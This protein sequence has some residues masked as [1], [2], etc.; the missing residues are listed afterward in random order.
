MAPS[1]NHQKLQ[2]AHKATWPK[3]TQPETWTSY[4]L[5]LTCHEYEESQRQ[6]QEMIQQ[7]QSMPALSD[8]ETEVDPQEAEDEMNNLPSPLHTHSRFWTPEYQ[9]QREARKRLWSPPLTPP[10]S[11]MPKYSLQ[12]SQRPPPPRPR[13]RQLSPA[14]TPP[15]PTSPS[16]SPHIQLQLPPNSRFNRVRKYKPHSPPHRPTIRSMKTSEQ[17]S[18]HVPRG[19]VEVL[20]TAGQGRSTTFE[21]CLKDGIVWFVLP[22][23][24]HLNFVRLGVCG[25][26]EI[27]CRLIDNGRKYQLMLL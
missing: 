2:C 10:L 22:L 8:N 17:L 3:W 7:H 23:L 12:P 19:L 26:D 11:G 21:Q 4:R 18:L 16:T 9:A 24:H 27:G 6:T 5:A 1:C 13:P 20:S 14:R 15:K 25:L